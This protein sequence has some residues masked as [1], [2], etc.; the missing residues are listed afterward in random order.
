[1]NTKSGRKV[2]LGEAPLHGKR[3]GSQAQR[4]GHMEEENTRS[5]G[6]SG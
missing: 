4:R 2:L 1:M 3:P 5:V 6:L